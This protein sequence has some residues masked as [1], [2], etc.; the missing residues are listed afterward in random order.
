MT[1]KINKPA[2]NLREELASLRNQG[3]LP[4]EDKL[5]LDNLL[6][7]GDFSNGLA[8][9]E[10]TESPT[11]VTVTNGQVTI[12][13][14]QYRAIKQTLPVTVGK[15][16]KVSIEVV[17]LNPNDANDKGR[18]YL[19]I[20]NDTDL[21]LNDSSLD[22]GVHTFYVKAVAATLVV[23]PSTRLQT[24]QITFDN[25][26]VQEVDENLLTNG[27]FES[28]SGW[29]SYGASGS[30]TS[31]VLTLTNG[32]TGHQGLVQDFKVRTGRSYTIT[33]KVTG[34]TSTAK[35]L[36]GSSQGNGNLHN[37]IVSAGATSTIN[38]TVVPTSA[39]FFVSLQISDANGTALYESLRVTEGNHQVIKSIPYGYDV[40]DVYIDGELARE[41]EAYDYEVKSDGINQW[42][43][44]TVEP[45]A[46]TE[47]VVIGV[48]K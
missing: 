24:G 36:I 10:L 28:L 46:T 8:S 22:I 42:L 29:T 21:Y 7:N 31:G 16:Y 26:S 38:V 12:V 2:I 33:G 20:T 47:T 19:G 44:P 3:G 32:S 4:K 37:A 6:P 13:P 1:V 14:T 25:V 23:R 34:G 35:L 41:G 45:T 30:V 43:K 39:N 15:T 18:L 11:S 27:T 5:Y 40:K 17:A 48:H 9:W